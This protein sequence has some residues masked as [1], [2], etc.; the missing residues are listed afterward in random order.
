MI[1]IVHSL[2]VNCMKTVKVR[3]TVPHVK[4]HLLHLTLNVC[5]HGSVL[6]LYTVAQKYPL[7]I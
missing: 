4:R 5:G 6:I 3:V 2:K 7:L 1:K